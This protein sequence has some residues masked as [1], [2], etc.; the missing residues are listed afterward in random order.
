MGKEGAEKIRQFSASTQLKPPTHLM[1]RP[2]PK[3]IQSRHMQPKFLRLAELSQAHAER[4][5]VCARDGDRVSDEG[6]ADVVDAGTVE[7]EDV[8]LQ[9]GRNGQG[10]ASV[11]GL[12]E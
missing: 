1:F 3:H 7:A 8:G 5:E 6:F 11:S 10:K 12:G 2:P 9:E 4:D